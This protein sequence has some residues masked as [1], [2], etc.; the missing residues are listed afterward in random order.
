MLHLKI[1]KGDIWDVVPQDVP[2]KIGTGEGI[3][4]AVLIENLTKRY[5]I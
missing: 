4:Y 2:K 3:S 1:I 5:L